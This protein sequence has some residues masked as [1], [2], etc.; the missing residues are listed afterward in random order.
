MW[1]G[2]VGD[3]S[4]RRCDTR[5]NGLMRNRYRGRSVDT[6]PQAVSLPLS[7]AADAADGSAELGVLQLAASRQ[8][9]VSRQPIVDRPDL[10]SGS[11]GEYSPEVL[12]ARPRAVKPAKRSFPNMWIKGPLAGRHFLRVP[13][14]T[15]PGQLA[16]E[17]QRATADAT[18]ALASACPGRRKPAQIRQPTARL[19]RPRQGPSGP[20]RA[21]PCRCQ[22]S[23]GMSLAM[24]RVDTNGWK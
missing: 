7:T 5:A 16:H 8:I 11:A 23:L 14:A 15:R 4:P 13:P 9:A 3:S 10:V 22:L 19:L 24:D 17:R 18:T 1:H 12:A 20:C 2:T 21:V 6:E